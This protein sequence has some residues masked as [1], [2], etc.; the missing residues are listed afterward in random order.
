M[1]AYPMPEQV[2]I[3]IKKTAPSNWVISYEYPDFIGVN[4]PS[5]TDEQIIFVGDI[6]GHFGFNDQLCGDICGDMEGITDSKEI[7]LNFWE[8]VGKFYP[9][10]VKGE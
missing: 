2:G 1:S 7:A 3:E 6:N 10:L 8:Q 4:H 5:F 9:E